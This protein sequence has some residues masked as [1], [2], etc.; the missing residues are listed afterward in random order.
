MTRE[1]VIAKNL[2]NGPIK[3]VITVP[4]CPQCNGCFSKDEEYLRLCFTAWAADCS[5]DARKLFVSKVKRSIQRRHAIGRMVLAKMD[6]VDSYT[7]RGIYLG[8]K[9]GGPSDTGRL[10]QDL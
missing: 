7:P 3:N 4:S 5:V 8:L 6:L 9:T 1:H 10:A 2:Y